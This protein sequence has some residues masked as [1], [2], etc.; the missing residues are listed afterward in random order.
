MKLSVIILAAGRGSRMGAGLPKVLRPIMG[1]PMLHH[2]LHTVSGLEPEQILSVIGVD[3]ELVKQS[4][5]SDPFFPKVTWVNQA[6][7]LGTAHAVQQAL[8]YIPDDHQILVMLGDVPGVT[9]EDLQ[10]L[11]QKAES[12]FALMTT[13]LKNPTGFGRVLRDDTHKVIGIVEQVD[14]TEAEQRINEINAGIMTMPAKFLKEALPLITADNQ[15]KEYYL[16]DALPIWLKKNSNIQVHTVADSTSVHGVN[17]M[18]DLQMVNQFMQRRLIDRW[19]Q[20][21]VWVHDPNRLVI[22]GPVS[23]APGAELDVDVTLCGHT[24]VQAGAVIGVGCIL[25][26][27]TIAAGVEVR[28]Y[29]IL[30]EVTIAKDARIGPFAVITAETKIGEASELGCFVEVKRSNIGAKVKAKHLTYIGD[31]HIEHGVNIGAGVVVC[32]YDGANKHRTQI[33]EKAF[34]GANVNL[35]APVVVHEKAFI[36]AGTTVRSDAPAEQ[37]TLATVPERHI[38]NWHRPCKSSQN[39][40]ESS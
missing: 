3:A 4:I 1:Q 38:K 20:N 25:R 37:L 19:M 6:E 5:Q 31:A 9:L 23:V 27:C 22:R 32:N 21:G 30:E 7:Q 36:A 12:G 33:K 15:Q 24:E 40:S 28:P 10:S 16:P 29:S 35:V 39:K 34:V 26:N 18:R 13:R 17:T 2:V 8:P 14:A 11:V